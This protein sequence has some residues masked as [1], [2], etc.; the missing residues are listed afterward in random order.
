MNRL[1]VR[2][3][4][5]IGIAVII[6]GVLP[7]V[8]R[9]LFVKPFPERPPTIPPLTEQFQLPDI[10]PERL[11]NYSKA[12]EE[13]LW[14]IGLVLPAMLICYNLTGTLEFSCYLVAG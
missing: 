12:L 8:Y 9:E 1:W 2:L 6:V 11:Q 3:S 14:S 10:P 7:F 4:L 5:L 13:K